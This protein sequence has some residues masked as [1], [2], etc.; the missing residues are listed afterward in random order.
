MTRKVLTIIATVLLFAMVVT[1][2]SSGGSTNTGS[3]KQG[4][5]TINRINKSKDAGEADGLAQVDAVIAAVTIDSEGKI[6][7]VNI[8][9]VQ[10]KVAFTKDGKLATDPATLVKTKTELGDEYGMAKASSLNKEWYEQIDALEKWLTGKKLSDIEG[11]KLTDGK[12]D[13]LKTSVT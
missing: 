7:A 4:L 9:T 6:L 8:D 10:A 3:I 5:G 2:C 13:D 12:A 1:A 11:M